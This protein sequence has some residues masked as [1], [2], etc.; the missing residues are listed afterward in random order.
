MN[1]ILL[2]AG[3]VDLHAGDFSIGFSDEQHQE[4]LLVIQKGTL[5]EFPECGVGIENFI[6]E[7]DIN[8]MLEDISTEFT[9]DGMEVKSISYNELTGEL[10]YDAN[11]KGK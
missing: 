7:S 4:H 11:Y 10:N 1:D 8:Q 2:I 5:K 9:K 3:E 6:N